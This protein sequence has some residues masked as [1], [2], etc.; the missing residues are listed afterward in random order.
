[1]K[2]LVLLIFC[3]LVAV[4]T[5]ATIQPTYSPGQGDV[6]DPDY[7]GPCGASCMRRH[8]HRGHRMHRMHGAY[9]DRR[10]GSDS[11]RCPYYDMS[12]DEKISF[13]EESLDYLPPDSYRYAR[14]T[15]MLEELMNSDN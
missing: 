7:M 2:C 14:H 6:P 3:V 4:C 1:M 13:L 8:G 12:L 5:A 10:L 15:R 11:N 9:E